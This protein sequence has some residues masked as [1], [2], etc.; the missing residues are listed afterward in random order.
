MK[1]KTETGIGAGHARDAGRDLS[2]PELDDIGTG[3]RPVQRTACR[4]KSPIG[5]IAVALKR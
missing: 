2:G 4:T 5:S 1:P 3:G